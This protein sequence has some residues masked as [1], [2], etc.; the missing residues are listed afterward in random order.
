MSGNLVGLRV[1][2][3][4]SRKDKVKPFPRA[5]WVAKLPTFLNIPHWLVYM[6]NMGHFMQKL[7]IGPE[8]IFLDLED[9]D[10]VYECMCLSVGKEARGKGLGTELIR[11]GYEIAKKVNIMSLGILV[12]P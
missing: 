8:Y 7:R 2:K 6:G 3:I 4:V 10:M 1:G 12:N 9:A 11:R 5:D